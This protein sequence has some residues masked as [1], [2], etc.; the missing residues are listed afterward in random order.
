MNVND[1]AWVARSLVQMGWHESDMEHAD[2][3]FINTCSVREKPQHKTM[4]M[5]GIIRDINPKASVAVAGCVAQQMGESIWERNAHVRLVLGSDGIAMAPRAFA[6]IAK[7]PRL[8]LSYL[9]FTEKFPDREPELLSFKNVENLPTGAPNIAMKSNDT[10]AFVN[11]MQGC[12]NY[13]AY[14][15]VPYTRGPRKSRATQSIIQECK[16][17]LARGTCDI[18]LLGQNVNVFGQDDGGDGTSFVQLLYKVAELDK[19]QRLHIMTSHP[20]DFSD[21]VIQA[22]KEISVIAPRLH[23]PLQAGSDAILKSMGRGYTNAHFLKLVEKLRAARPDLALSTDIIVGFPGETEEDFKETLRIVKEVGFIASFSY[24]YSDRPGT[25]AST[26]TNKIPQDV[27]LE[28]LK[29]LIAQQNEQGEKWL[30][31]LEGTTTTVLLE[32]HSRKPKYSNITESPE[33]RPAKLIREQEMALAELTM[34]IPENSENQRELNAKQIPQKHAD[35]GDLTK[36]STTIFK[37]HVPKQASVDTPNH[38]SWQG[39]DS[40]G[41]TINLLIPN[42]LQHKAGNIV[43]VRIIRAKRHSLLAELH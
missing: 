2:F 43:P 18:T 20:R 41:N 9:E 14:C 10:R 21:D 25:R 16:E 6:R 39:H 11:I 19:I 34:L 28:R 27:Q 32:A 3:V 35:A 36:E 12:D 30:K 5:L 1:S 23:L 38:T 37:K 26:M 4:S 13:C 8:R 31:S 42:H 17:W 24:C 15:I 40:W 22:Y 29:R 33:D 7:N